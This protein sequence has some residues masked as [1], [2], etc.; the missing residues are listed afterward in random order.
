MQIKKVALSNFR[1]HEYYEFEPVENGITAITGNSGAGKSSILDAVSWALYGLKPSGVSAQ[2]SLFRRGADPKKD[3]CYVE[4]DLTVDGDEVKV[5][6]RLHNGKTAECEVF[7]YDENGNQVQDAGPAVSQAELHIRRLL[8]K[9]SNGFTSA[10]YVRQKS[11][12]DL[13]KSGAGNKTAEVVE[14]LIG[15]SS[16]SESLVMAKDEVRKLKASINQNTSSE[17]T[18]DSMEKDLKA[19]S[20]R[21]HIVLNKISSLREL[22]DDLIAESRERRSDYED[23]KDRFYRSETLKQAI[24]SL[25]TAVSDESER[26]SEYESER[27][28][29]RE[30]LASVGNAGDYN[31]IK[32]S[33]D[34]SER[35]LNSVIRAIA[36][37]ESSMDS[38]EQSLTDA[39][40]E[41][42]SIFEK[43]K[44]SG[45]Y[46]DE[47][48]VLSSLDDP[49]L[50]RL[51]EDRES[52]LTEVQ[53]MEKKLLQLDEEQSEVKARGLELKGA[54]E[55]IDEG[56]CPTCLRDFDDAE[57]LKD[58]YINEVKS[59]RKQFS[60]GSKKTSGIK[61]SI[62]ESTVFADQVK[63]LLDFHARLGEGQKSITSLKSEMKTKRA[64]EQSLRTEVQAKRKTLQSA[65]NVKA[66]RESRDRVS[67]NLEKSNA[68]LSSKSQELSSKKSELRT[69]N[70][71]SPETLKKKASKIK[72]LD[73]RARAKLDEKN[74][75]EREEVGLTKDVEHLRESIDRAKEELKRYKEQL[76]Q[77]SSAVASESLLR[78]FKQDRV[79]TAIPQ[80]ETFASDLLSKFTNGTF[81]EMTL[82]S[83]FKAT[84]K[85]SDGN[86]FQAGELSGGEFSASALALRLAISMLLNVGSR[87]NLMILDEVLN[88]QDSLRAENILNTIKE[89]MN[90]QIII[91]SHSESLAS[92]VDKTVEL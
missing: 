29:I 64:Q 62:S 2:S 3:K 59:L 15:I 10:V 91:I 28:R 46:D 81:T 8:K 87:D 51:R 7:S 6:R 68:A 14:K 44:S 40:S 77:Y 69:I 71:P 27:T 86:E 66:L 84:V 72:A 83:K 36:K 1:Q 17:D 53:E 55:S 16:L 54:I 65:E 9:D 12:D 20:D 49:F 61:E 92:V 39:K 23:L 56:K 33:T 21:L 11:V 38:E 89:T 79:D 18:V 60:D 85:R 35:E 37:I 30:E 76:R 75:L 13:I 24:E 34:E 5:I 58:H 82:D 32:A 31:S 4:L 90:G 42:S 48:L 70:A 50:K 88:S 47:R 63:D 41:I 22:T 67:K 52:T 78:D 73:E 19:K 26:K 57:S 43:W 25:E 74:S 45:H 80:I